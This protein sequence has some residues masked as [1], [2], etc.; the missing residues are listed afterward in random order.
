[1]LASTKNRKKSGI[2][3]NTDIKSY[4]ALTGWKPAF[5]RKVGS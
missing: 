1:V 3:N 4:R 2:P 5:A